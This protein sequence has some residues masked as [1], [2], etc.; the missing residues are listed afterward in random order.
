M[1]QHHLKAQLAQAVRL[2]CEAMLMSDPALYDRYR[3]GVEVY[4]EGAGG[5]VVLPDQRA[6]EGAETLPPSHSNVASRRLA[7][8]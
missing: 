6:S 8:R 2:Y 3:S 5:A 7:W 4:D 1:T